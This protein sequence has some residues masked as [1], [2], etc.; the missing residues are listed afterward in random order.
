MNGYELVDDS[1]DLDYTVSENET[2]ESE[3]DVSLIDE[4][5]CEDEDET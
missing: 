2:E 5:D 3:S 1:E 4:N